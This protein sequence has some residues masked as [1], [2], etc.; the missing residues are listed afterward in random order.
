MSLEKGN[1]VKF[2][3]IHILESYVTG[4]KCYLRANFLIS[5]RLFSVGFLNYR[6]SLSHLSSLP[7]SLTPVDKIK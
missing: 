1:I 7:L 3:K 6:E 2:L 5:K 4:L